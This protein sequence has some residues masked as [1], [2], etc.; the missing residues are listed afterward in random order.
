MK[1]SV[2]LLFLTLFSGSTLAEFAGYNHVLASLLISDNQYNST[3]AIKL[4]Y[5]SGIENEELMDLIAYSLARDFS[6]A[7]KV[8]LN[9]WHAK[10]LGRTGNARYWSLLNMIL[11]SAD[12]G[13][14]LKKYT[15]LAITTLPEAHENAFNPDEYQYSKV[16]EQIHALNKIS[17]IDVDVLNKVRRGDAVDTVY[18]LIGGPSAIYLFSE[19]GP[20]VGPI[21]A[22]RRLKIR[23]L[24]LMYYGAGMLELKSS[25]IT[26]IYP[27]L[28]AFRMFEASENKILLHQIY[29]DQ[30]MMIRG[31]ATQLASVENLSIGEADAIAYR[32]WMERN[33]TEEFLVD[34]VAWLCK[35]HVKIKNPRYREMFGQ[36]AADA[37]D[38]KIRKYAKSVLKDMPK[39]E[40]EQ[41]KPESV[42]GSGSDSKPISATGV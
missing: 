36:I 13:E 3:A 7:E 25:S 37:P 20:M 14:K 4:I 28:P 23:Q 5:N 39:K 22:R 29:T 10:T 1:K 21:G 16:K 27:V 26:N 2:F 11:E 41:F 24:H 31:A 18:E 9:S 38:S 30:T 19:A 42:G 32:I 40:V 8:D 35:P 33:A 15:G 12:A 17:Y 6:D 34:A